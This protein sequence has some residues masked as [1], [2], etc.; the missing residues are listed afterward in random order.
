[1]SDPDSNRELVERLFQAMCSGDLDVIDELVA[2]NFVQH[3]PQ[4]QSGRQAFRDFIGAVA[5]VESKVYRVL[6]DGDLVAIHHHFVSFGSAVVDIFR[7]VDGK[8]VEHW[9]VLQPVPETTASGL[10]LFTQET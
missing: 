3:N 1:M 2:D 4:V 10:H 6:A 9:D 5:P 7:V 8:V